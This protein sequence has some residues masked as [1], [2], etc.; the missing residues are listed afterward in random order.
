MLTRAWD[1]LIGRLSG[2]LPFRF[3]L[4]PLVAA[5]LAIGAGLRDARA[6]RPPFLWT[7]LADRREWR[8][9]LRSGWRDIGMVFVVAVALDA[10]Y[11]VA[12]L[13]F[14]YPLQTLIVAC[15]LALVP[16][17]AIRGPV[18]R[19]A[20]TAQRRRRGRSERSVSMAAALTRAGR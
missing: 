6:G 12:V 5:A 17:A 3:V 8:A 10:L 11:Q 7:V 2:P 15:L 9:T 16:Y 14:F 13:R 18:T 4:Q 1:Q 19:L 20:G